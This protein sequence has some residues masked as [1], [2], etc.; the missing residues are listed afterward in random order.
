MAAPRLIAIIGATGAQGIPIVR[1]LVQSGSY[2]VRALTRDASHPRF[3]ELQSFSP[4]SS[5]AAVE[6]VVGTFTSEDDLRATFRGAWGAFVNIDG[7]NAGEKTEMFW[8]IRAYEIA[9]EEGVKVFVL[10]NLDYVYKK[11]GYKPEF[12]LV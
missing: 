4:S 9:L 6:P 2:T 8:T 3:L 7:F 12:R 5:S 1:D 11:G 10:G